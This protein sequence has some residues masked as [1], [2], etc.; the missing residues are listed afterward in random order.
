M[1]CRDCALTMVT[2]FRVLLDRVGD[3]EW[4]AWSGRE[5]ESTFA[6]RNGTAS[7]P[8]GREL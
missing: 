1:R 3:G 4:K 5:S 2:A 6:V 7:K 8:D